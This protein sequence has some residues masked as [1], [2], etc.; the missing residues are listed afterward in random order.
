MAGPEHIAFD[1][2]VASVGLLGVGLVVLSRWSRREAATANIREQIERTERN[3]SML[4]EYGH[5]VEAAYDGVDKRVVVKL[6]T[7]VQIEFPARLVEGLA[8]ASPDELDRIDISPA[9]LGLHW[10]ACGVDV[11]LP[12]LFTGVFGSKHWLAGGNP[13]RHGSLRSLERGSRP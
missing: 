1:I 11:F 3:I 9:G 4:R 10:P 5:A 12:A 6:N 8:S 7:G 2:F 13:S